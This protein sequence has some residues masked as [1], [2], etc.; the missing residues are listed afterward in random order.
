MVFIWLVG[1]RRYMELEANCLL[2][3]ARTVLKLTPKHKDRKA[4]FTWFK[5]KSAKAVWG[6][7]K[8]RHYRQ[9]LRKAMEEQNVLG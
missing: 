3:W 6:T 5:S 4:L 8:A 1:I 7:D 9:A 2:P